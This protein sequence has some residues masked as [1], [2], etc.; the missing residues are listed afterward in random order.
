MPY[1][2]ILAMFVLKTDAGYSLFRWIAIAATDL[3][4]QSYAG[5]EFFVREDLASQGLFFFSTL[6]AIIFLQVM[7]HMPLSFRHC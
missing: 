2:Q 1:I 3:L 7:F 4:N 5:V 6:G